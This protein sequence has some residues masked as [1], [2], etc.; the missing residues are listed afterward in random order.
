LREPGRDLVAGPIEDAAGAGDARVTATA[1]V[2]L[3]EIGG[4]GGVIVSHYVV[5]HY[6]VSNYV[7]SNYVI[8][9]RGEAKPVCI[10]YRKRTVNFY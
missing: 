9:G 5:S 4:A 3:D 8:H 7:V 1:A 10:T 2:K 6:M